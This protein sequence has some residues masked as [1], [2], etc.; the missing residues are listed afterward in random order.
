LLNAPPALE[1][2]IKRHVVGRLREYFAVTAPGLEFLCLQE[3][4][5]LPLTLHRARVCPGGVI[6]DGRLVDCF[7]ANLHLRTANRVLMRIGAFKA[8]GFYEL[9]TKCSNLPWELFLE[10]DQPIEFRI[11]SKKSRLYHTRAIADRFR[12]GLAERMSSHRQTRHDPN[13]APQPQKIFIRVVKDRFT[14]SL[15]SSGA[16]LHK[17]GIK[18]KGSKAPLR[19]TTAAAILMLA[20]YMPPE[21]LLDPMCGSGTFSVEAAMLASNIPAGFFRNFAFTA[22]P[23]HRQAKL[24]WEHLKAEA[25]KRISV[26]KGPLVLAS[27]IDRRACKTFEAVIGG[28]R[29]A[30]A[31]DISPGD[32]FELD[33]QPFARRPGLVVINPPY[34]RRIDSPKGARELL[35]RIGNKLLRHFGGWKFA[36]IL[37]S[38]SMLEQIPFPAAVFPFFHGGLQVVAAVGKVPPASDFSRS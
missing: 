36:L 18:T 10:P 5:S 19:E 15:D 35:G 27:D 4:Q 31:I 22:W 9:E 17:R 3:L 2:R 21:P 13:Q 7:I 37:P 20:G 8:T 29:F 14:V 30:A 24:R 34:G 25:E 6:F 33:P 38:Q 11:R 26:P 12:S 28:H 32:F 1:K 23:A 16:N